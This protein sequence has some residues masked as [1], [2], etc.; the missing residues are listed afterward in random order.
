MTEVRDATTASVGIGVATY[1]RPELLHNLL[2]SLAT[3]ASISEVCVYVVD[4]DANESGREVCEIDY[5]FRLIYAV[6]P[7][8][9]I[10][11]ARN[12]FLDLAKAEDFLIF[13]DDDE[14]V[15]EDWLSELRS[16]Q[17][18]LCADVVWGPVIPVFPPSAPAWAIQGGFFDR[19]RHST[20]HELKLAATNNAIV[21]REAIEKLTEPRFRE[22]FSETGGSDSDLF[23]RMYRSGAVIRWCDEAIVREHVPTERMTWDWVAQRAERTGNVRA[24]LLMSDG[25]RNQVVLEGMARVGVGAFRNVVG[26]IR[27]KVP[28]SREVNTYRRGLGMLRALRGSYVREYRR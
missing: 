23:H 18:E 19:D 16:A 11:A 25:H 26:K 2:L 9:G 13:I 21:R 5:G 14:F 22:S 28:T 4:N 12:S 24:R 27:G 20:G 17:A 7:K 15:D 6:E 8:P 1:R 3:T 10:A